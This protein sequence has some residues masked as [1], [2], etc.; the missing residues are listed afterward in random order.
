M[1]K[2]K[3]S[4]TLIKS[5]HFWNPQSKLKRR[6]KRIHPESSRNIFLSM[7]HSYVNISNQ[8]LRG[9]VSKWFFRLPVRATLL[10]R[11]TNEGLYF[12]SSWFHSLTAKKMMDSFYN[13]ESDM[14]RNFIS[15][16]YQNMLGGVRKPEVVLLLASFHIKREFVF[17]TDNVWK[18]CDDVDKISLSCNLGII[19][20]RWTFLQ[21]LKTRT[22]QSFWLLLSEF[23]FSYFPPPKPKEFI[24]V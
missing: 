22:D 17:L 18:F 19:L 10:G 14:E 4:L 2:S 23:F 3:L 15:E 7:L 13:P 20:F 8:H 21:P 11:M 16:P 9:K 5:S 1:I 6:K 24:G 12:T